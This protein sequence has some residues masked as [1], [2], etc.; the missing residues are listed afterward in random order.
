MMNSTEPPPAAQEKTDFAR[1]QGM[2]P[3]QRS[4]NMGGAWKMLICRGCES[5]RTSFYWEFLSTG[6]GFIAD[7]PTFLLDRMKQH[8]IQ[9]R[10]RN[11]RYGERAEA[12][13]FGGVLG[14]FRLGWC[15]CICTPVP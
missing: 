12:L 1:C 3:Q 14:I 5:Q 7:L 9:Q 6:F 10:P 4:R 8:K 11:V 2:N 15:P 13:S